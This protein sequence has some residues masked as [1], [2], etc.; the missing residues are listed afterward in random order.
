MT[1][2]LEKQ[3]PV[4]MTEDL[5]EQLRLECFDQRVPMAAYIRSAVRVA[6]AA[7]LKVTNDA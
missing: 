1:P 3:L 5:Y 7:D 2:S 4:Y 6:L